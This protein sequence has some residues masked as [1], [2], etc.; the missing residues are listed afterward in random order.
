M[1]LCA[2]LL[3]LSSLIGTVETVL[4]NNLKGSPKPQV[5][6]SQNAPLAIPSTSPPDFQRT[7]D[8]ALSDAQNREITLSDLLRAKE[9]E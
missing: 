4:D 2:I 1:K 5:A 7:V 6:F 9:G 3:S 8:E